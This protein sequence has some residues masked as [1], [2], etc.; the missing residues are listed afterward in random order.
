MP[1]R[2]W[3]DR[4]GNALLALTLLCTALVEL[5]QAPS[6]QLS[7]TGGRW[8]LAL[9][10]AGMTLPL[11]LR[12][13]APARTLLVQ[14]AALGVAGALLR[15]SQGVPLS[16]FA[17]LLIGFYSVGANCDDRRAIRGGATALAGIVGIDAAFAVFQQHG[18]R[19]AVWLSLAVAWLIGRELRRRRG[20]L[21]LLRER[22]NRL[23]AEREA[24]ARSAVAEERTRIARE[25]HDVVAHSV[26]VIV[27]QAQAGTRLLE[28]PQQ[29]RSAFRSIETTGRE[30][31]VELRRLLGILRTADAQTAVGPQ[32]G[33]AS[34]DSLLE[35]VREAGLAVTV[36]VEGDP[37][38][39][40]PGI[41]LSAY[42]IVQ[43][44]L[45]NTLK[46]AGPAKA[47]ILL[48]Y[49]AGALELEVVDDG[50]GPGPGGNGSGHGLVGMRERAALYGGELEAGEGPQGGYAV[51]ARLPLARRNGT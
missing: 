9:P 21:A 42:R 12:R 51:R 36:S 31:L 6:D 28:D 48:R 26:S 1:M 4:W 25:L 50:S 41:D 19:P 44:A 5:V 39:L 14:V 45:T 3:L 23:E 35:Q 20:E 32:P 15:N 27:V 38:P 18:V 40:P 8:T 43:E 10:L 16:G 2:A 49:A 37:Q 7:A 24:Q 30:A 47:R 34:L 22:A 29:A 33:L 13:R 11:A 17:A 46:H